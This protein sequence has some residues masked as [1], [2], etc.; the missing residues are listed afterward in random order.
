MIDIYCEE[1][2]LCSKGTG[3]TDVGDICAVICYHIK[4]TRLLPA[5]CPCSG[6]GGKRHTHTHTV[7]TDR[8]ERSR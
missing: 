2:E 7:V 5:L 8:F 4:D 6:V 3:V 1:L